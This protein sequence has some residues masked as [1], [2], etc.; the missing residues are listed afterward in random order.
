MGSRSN[1][2]RST[3]TWA[4]GSVST[5]AAP[6]ASTVTLDSAAATGRIA[7]TCT[8]TE[9]RIATSCVKGLKPGAVTVRW[10]ELGGIF[11]RRKVPSAP[12]SKRLLVTGDGIGKR[13]GRLGNQGAGLIGHRAF[14]GPRISERLR[15]CRTREQERMARLKALFIRV[16]GCRRSHKDPALAISV[17]AGEAE[18]NL[19]L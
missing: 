1:A 13:D 9:L 11:S 16:I 3:S 14:D 18:P 7:L 6:L 2:L 12:E 19:K 8:G 4:L 10:Y 5:T 15:E 17:S